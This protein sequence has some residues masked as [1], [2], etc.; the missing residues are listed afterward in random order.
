[1]EGAGSPDA[2]NITSDEE[3]GNWVVTPDPAGT[4]TTRYATFV[5]K[6]DKPTKLPSINQPIS[7]WKA[8]AEWMKHFNSE[9][10]CLCLMYL[11]YVASR[12]R[13]VAPLSRNRYVYDKL[14]QSGWHIKNGKFILS[15]FG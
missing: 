13:G 10:E 6:K 3:T 2:Y 14:A 7:S 8:N 11:D 5:I 1:M 9:K 15:N 12:L 4:E